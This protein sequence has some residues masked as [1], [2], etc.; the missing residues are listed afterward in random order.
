MQVV[1]HNTQLLEDAVAHVLRQAAIPSLQA[2]A[3][4]SERLERAAALRRMSIGGAVALA[5]VGLGLGLFLALQRSAEPPPAEPLVNQPAV[6]QPDPTAPSSPVT[7]AD[8][9]M[10]PSSTPVQ[11]PQMASAPDKPDIVTTDYTKFKTLETVRFNSEWEIV[12]GHHFDSE[13]DISWS[14]AWCYTN[15]DLEGLPVRVSLAD[16]DAPS[17][18][19]VGPLASEQTLTQVGLTQVMA[20]EL[21][22]ACPWLDGARDLAEVAAPGES[23]APELVAG[24]FTL[25]DRRLRYVGDIDPTFPDSLTQYAFDHLRIT[26]NGGSIDAAV[27]AGEWL[28]QNGKSVSVMNDCTSACAFV[29]AGGYERRLEPGG[30]VGVHR[31][32]RVDGGGTAADGI[33]EGQMVSSM[34]LSYL[35]KMGIDSGL[36]HAM[37]AVPSKD[38]LYLD[39]SDL[40]TWRLLTDTSP[41]AVEPW[42]DELDDKAKAGVQ[43]DLILLGHY[44]G[45]V[46][47]VFGVG[48]KRAVDAYRAER[49]LS[50]AGELTSTERRHLREVARR[51][52]ERLGFA[53]VTDVK[54]GTALLVPKA[55][56]PRRSDTPTGYAYYSADGSSMIRVEAFIGTLPTLWSSAVAEEQGKTITYSTSLPERFVVA[57]TMNGQSFYTYMLA[58]GVSSR[59]F[60]FTWSSGDTTDGVVALNMAAS[61]F[62]RFSDYIG[63]AGGR[64][65]ETVNS[66]LN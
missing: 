63:S 32:Y 46:D 27:Q 4:A 41:V 23:S 19:P 16:R 42:F 29:L 25:T 14:H 56:L 10:L 18:A 39:T 21:A 20:R 38:M 5:A 28:R 53:I 52:Y 45:L 30:R 11:D 17:S 60:T 58:D 66:Y 50:E 24:T 61:H 13:T 37:A 3:A 64:L 12:A 57:G 34:L 22:E 31:F 26:S 48:T 54:S 7:E 49:D 59:G 33:A 62:V 1:R 9:T 40:R 55:L 44:Q 15:R 35:S 51:A 36:F 2:E 43:V 6:V 65:H 8:G 47:G